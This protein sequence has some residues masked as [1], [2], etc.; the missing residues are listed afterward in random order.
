ME[1]VLVESVPL[2]VLLRKLS[3]RG[4][5]HPTRIVSTTTCAK[6][7]VKLP[8][9]EK[10]CRFLPKGLPHS[11]LAL[12]VRFNSSFPAGHMQ[13]VVGFWHAHQGWLGEKAC[14]LLNGR[15][16]SLHVEGVDCLSHLFTY[17]LFVLFPSLVPILAGKVCQLLAFFRKM[18]T[19]NAPIM[20]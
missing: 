9:T 3:R 4:R 20:T 17:L 13:G 11:P 18:A 14:H 12:L 15:I 6:K 7:R 10:V 1:M 2:G 5:G 8:I 19:E 16:H